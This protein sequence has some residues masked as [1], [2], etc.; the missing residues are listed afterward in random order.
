MH[1]PSNERITFRWDYLAHLLKAFA[2]FGLATVAVNHHQVAKAYGEM[3]LMGFAGVGLWLV[4]F[5]FL[6]VGCNYLWC[7][8]LQKLGHQGRAKRRGDAPGE[9]P[10]R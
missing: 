5:S 4:G 8:G 1:K 3:G 10:E 6:L 9:L 7:L 2:F